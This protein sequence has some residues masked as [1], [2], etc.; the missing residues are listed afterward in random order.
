MRWTGESERSPATRATKTPGRSII[1]NTISII[2]YQRY[3]H[4]YQSNSEFS[5]RASQVHDSVFRFTRTIRE[6]VWDLENRAADRNRS[7]GAFCAPRE[8]A[9]NARESVDTDERNLDGNIKSHNRRTS[10][11]TCNIT[12]V[13]PRHCATL[14]SRRE[15]RGNVNM[16]FKAHFRNSNAWQEAV[17]LITRI[18][19]LPSRRAAR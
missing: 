1:Y 13:L 15:G 19:F 14:L 17:V 3:R 2:I 16:V 18:L 7:A 12:A 9:C 6:H 11:R 10:R 5:V 4:F 8:R